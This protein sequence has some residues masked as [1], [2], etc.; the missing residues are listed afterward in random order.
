MDNR[1]I[2]YTSSRRE[3]D[4]EERVFRNR[5][6]VA[7]PH[8]RA[9][10]YTILIDDNLSVRGEIVLFPPFDDTRNGRAEG[11][12]RQS[13]PSAPVGDGLDDFDDDIPF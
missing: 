6:G 9:D 3:I 12:Q 5:V 11:A 2:A 4:G 7:F 1:L 10:G 8:K 13:P